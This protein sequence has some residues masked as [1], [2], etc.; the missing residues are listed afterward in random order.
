VSKLTEAWREIKVFNP[1]AFAGNGNVYIDYRPQDS[2]RGGYSSGYLVIRPGFVTDPKA[3]WTEDGSKFFLVW[4][5]KDRANVFEQAKA[6]ASAKYG[7]KKWARTPYGSW[8]E[9]EFVKRR[10]AELNAALAKVKK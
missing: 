5:R 4:G 9:A 2:G 7:I 10:T 6:W 8:M 1:Y 3:H